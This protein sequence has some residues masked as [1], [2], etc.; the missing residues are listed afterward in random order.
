MGC[1]RGSRDRRG[2]GPEFP[3]PDRCQRETD[4]REGP[5]G[6]GAALR[7][8]EAVY[9]QTHTRREDRS[10]CARRPAT[11]RPASGEAAGDTQGQTRSITA[12]M[13]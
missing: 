10:G 7:H 5:C 9:A 3:E 13:P 12:A 6:W 4:E 8:P 2:R 11:S 1:A